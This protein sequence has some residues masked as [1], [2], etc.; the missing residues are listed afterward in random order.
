[1]NLPDGSKLSL[2]TSSLIRIEFDDHHRRLVLEHGEAYIEVAEDKSRP[3]SVRV[4]NRVVEAVGT[5]FNLKITPDQRIELIV[6]EGKVLVGVAEKTTAIPI[7]RIRPTRPVVPDIS[8]PSPVEEFSPIIPSSSRP[9]SAGEQLLL[10]DSDEEFKHVEPDEIK[11]K[12]SWR[13]G[14]IVF[15]GVSLEEALKEIQRYTTVEFVIRDE[16]LKKTHIVGH[17]K[18]GEVEELLA[19]LSANFDITYQRVNGEVILTKD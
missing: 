4:G 6:T 10:G 3:L 16:E 15:R 12:L 2:N 19:M 13:E 8:I 5:A 1:V 17:F 7:E 18:T 11:L 14:N 9:V